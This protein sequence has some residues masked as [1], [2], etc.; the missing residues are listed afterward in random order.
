MLKGIL[1]ISG[2][3]GLFKMITNAKNSI[4]V[5]SLIDGKRTPAYAT[6]KIS[7]LEDISIF[8]V[9]GD[10][11]LADVF[12]NI[13]EKSLDV[14]PKKAS[15]KELKDAFGQALPDYDDERVYVSDIKK[16]FAWYNLLKEKEVISA[17]AIEAYKKGE[18]EENAEENTEENED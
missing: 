3:P 7:S 18:D 5:E 10:T 13:F 6:S 12:V 4:I 11:K 17:D 9:D 1:A 16:V 8:T 2:K 14:N 15:S